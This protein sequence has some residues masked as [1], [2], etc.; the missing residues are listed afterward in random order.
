MVC[1][2]PSWL[3][4]RAAP[5]ALRTPRVNGGGGGAHLDLGQA[6]MAMLLAAS[7]ES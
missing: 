2:E 1:P 5:P 6:T 4:G 7:G 3:V